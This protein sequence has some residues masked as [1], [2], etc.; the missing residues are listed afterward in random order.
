MSGRWVVLDVA[1]APLPDADQYLD[2]TVRA[3]SNYKDAEKIAEY[4]R[5]KTAERLQMAATDV[6]LA[7]VTGLGYQTPHG[8]I[9][10][11]TAENEAQEIGLL[12]RVADLVRGEAGTVVITFGG[13]DFD[14]PLLMRRARYLDVPFP[15]ISTDRFKS[16]HRDLCLELSDRNPQRKRSL[17]FYAKRLGWSDITKPLSGAEEALVPVTDRW[18]E[19]A[20]SIRHDVTATCRLAQWMGIVERAT[21]PEMVAF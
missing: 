21:Q 10:L 4:I 3:P 13:F 11:L 7:R 9:G 14:L 5:E 16:P 8:P 6:D 12:K 19:L 18:V 15:A 1:T 17:Q 20:E 2:G